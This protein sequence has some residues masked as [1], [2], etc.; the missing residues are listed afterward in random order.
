MDWAGH[1][2]N[3]RLLVM[4]HKPAPIQITWHGHLNTT[5]LKAIDYRFTDTIADP[6]YQGVD[7]YS[8]ELYRLSVCTYCYA[9]PVVAQNESIK[10]KNLSSHL[11]FG[12]FNNLCKIT[13]EVVDLWATVL[14][15]IPNSRLLLKNRSFTC[16][17]TR[18]IF[19][20]KFSTHGIERSR[21]D[22]AGYVDS[23][24]SHLDCYDQVDIGL[25]T[26]PFNGAT[27]TCE[28]LWMGV[29]V[30]TLSG[31]RHV[32]RIGATM[33]NAVGLSEMVALNKNEFVQKA[34]RLANDPKGLMQL[35][36]IL[37]K[38]MKDSPLCNSR[39]FAHQI[40]LAYRE[41]WQRWCLK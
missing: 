37:R 20:E 2:R 16:D 15:S 19:Y 14:S 34:M 4:A 25:D 10:P 26:F 29:P 18:N 6:E 31:D 5:G 13:P 38:R 3:N 22:M 30:L 24:K 39:H 11:T 28:A 12:S 8:E 17:S 40:E 21:I 9:A 41:I 36:A 7:Q 32:S 1:T 23:K 35:R 33:L 27:T